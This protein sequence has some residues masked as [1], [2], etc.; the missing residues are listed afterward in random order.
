MSRLGRIARR[1]FLLGSA[2]VAGG[3]AIGYWA[4]KRPVANPLPATLP[5]GAHAFTPYVVIDADGVRV[6]APRA[7]VGQGVA[8]SLAALVAEEMD[9]DWPTVRIEHGPP[10]GA[11]YNGKVAAEGFPFAATD[12]G[13]LARGARGLGD[14]VAKFADLQ[15]TGGSTSVADAFDKM[16][17]AGAA[18]R[19]VLLSAAAERE[20]VPRSGLR[21]EAGAV[22]L[23]DGRRVPYPALAELAA[24]RDIPLDAEPKAPRDWRLLGRPMQRHDIIAKSTGTARYAIDMDLPDMV[25]A[26]VRTNPARGSLN[27]MDADA[28]AAMPGVLKIVPIDGGA[29]VIADN[30][31]TAMQAANAIDFSWGPPPFPADSATMWEQVAASFTEDRRDSRLKDEGDLGAALAEGEIVEAEYRVPYLAHAPLEPMTA[32]ARLADGRLDLWTGTQIPVFARD[33][34]ADRA[35]LDAG[36]VTLHVLPAGGSFGRRLEDDC[37]A[38]AVD[39]AMAMPGRPVKLTWSRE[40]DMARDFPRPMAMARG[41][42]AVSGGRVTGFDLSV[43]AQS[44]TASQMGRLGMPVAGPDVTIVAGAWDQPYAMPACRVT[45]YRVPEMV[46]VSSWR[47]VGASM[48]GFFHESFLDELIHAA[49]ADPL[50]ER[51]RLIDDP[52]SRKVLEAVGEMSGWAGPRPADGIG[53]G[54]AFTLSFGVPTAEIV[55]VRNTESGIAIDRV[56]VAA[57]VG[58]IID[59]INFENQMQGGVV[60]GLGHAMNCE[61]TFTEGRPDQNQLN[62]FEGM[63][64]GQCPEIAVHGLENGDTV[65][66]IG[67]PPVPPAAPALANAIFAATG[68]RIRDLPLWNAVD[69]A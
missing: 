20:G 58:R 12:S 54:V 35:G 67:E 4:W 44:V 25:F 24:G 43:A 17:Q 18:A 3:V 21:T 29:G 42:G 27:G 11:Y 30:S 34:A 46:P 5:E 32:V 41:R 39:L 22:I 7:E 66:G 37:I 40:E 57:E 62:L 6:I 50:E 2:A 28:A 23:P 16:R 31:W 38:Q 49:G 63:R 10:S 13:M 9:L 52:L 60:W 48:N 68:Q 33:R 47:S 36:A 61:L 55:E 69:F 59:P 56:W 14:A 45:G 53:R 19:A 65:R 26:T 8:S 51:L 1:T 64:I 15:I